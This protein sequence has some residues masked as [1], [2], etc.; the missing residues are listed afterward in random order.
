M[1][2]LLVLA[3]EQDGVRTESTPNAVLEVAEAAIWESAGPWSRP[4][5]SLSESHRQKMSG[6]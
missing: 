3:T 1:S 5:S 6:A 4:S 2:L